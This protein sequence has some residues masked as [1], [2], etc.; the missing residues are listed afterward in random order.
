M[1]EPATLAT[2]AQIG[3]AAGGVG[4]LVSAIGGKPSGGGSAQ[5]QVT[6]PPQQASQPDQAGARKRPQSA[7]GAPGT[8]LTGASGIDP[9][10]LTLGKNTLL[11]G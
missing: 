2:I 6:P 10:A 7:A 1:C 4:S 11:G 5:A 3:A 8:M 9:S